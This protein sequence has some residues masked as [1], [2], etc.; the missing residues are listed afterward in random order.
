[1]QPLPT[2]RHCFICGK[3]NTA[4]LQVRF[5]R[6][7]DGVR[8]T[9]TPARSF[10]GFDGVLQGGVAAGL[11]DDAMWYAIFAATGGV[12]MTAEL[13][14]RYKAPVPV[15][16]EL[17]VTGQLVEQRRNLYTC[18]ASLSGP[19]GRVLAEAVGKFLAAPQELA[20]RL[21]QQMS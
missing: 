2:S 19:D 14:V 18:A 11:M 4:G 17:T 1:M 15:E 10:E 3:E 8:A 7:P 20:E 21:H 13:T 9:V 16:Q 6:T 12:T 5:H